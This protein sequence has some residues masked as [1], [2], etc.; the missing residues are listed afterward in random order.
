[1]QYVRWCGCLHWQEIGFGVGEPGAG[2]ST[3]LWRK[4]FPGAEI[5]IME[6][7]DSPLLVPYSK[8][9]N[10]KVCVLTIACCSQL[11]TCVL[12]S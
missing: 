4:V 1:M 7:K 11:P 5:H 12:G 10:F 3:E 2:S 6:Y 9:F 8:A